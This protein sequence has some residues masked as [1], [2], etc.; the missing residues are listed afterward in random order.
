MSNNNSNV[1][2]RHPKKTLVILFFVFFL[3]LDFGGAAVL[4][5]LGL[6]EPSYTN[7][8]T[9]EAVYRRTDKIFHHTL[10]KN[11]T[12]EKA[13]WGGHH[14]TVHTNSLGFKDKAIREIKLKIDKPR[15]LFIGDSF[16][17]GVGIEYK[18]TF[19]GLVDSILN[20]K[21]INVLN[22]AATSYAPIIYLRKV[23]YLLNEVGLKF[24][25]LVVFVDLSD[26]EDEAMGYIFNDQRSVVSRNTIE[27]VGQTSEE[28]KDKPFSLKEFFT[29]YTIIT[30]R[31]RNLSAYLK[32]QKRSWHD[33]LNRR[34]ARWT[35]D[36][37]IYN[38]YGKTGLALAQQHMT[39]LKQLLDKHQIKMTL[40]VYPWPDQI[41]A[42]NYP[43]KQS[44]TWQAWTQQHNVP[45]V[46]LFPAFMSDDAEQT[47]KTY[48]INGDVH[49]NEKGHALVADQIL[50]ILTP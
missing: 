2:E 40:A 30:G 19:V 15:I 11:V 20:K 34:R 29:E 8:K 9:L 47:I 49:W 24:D 12:Q 10:K 22:A 18:N 38:Q 48:Y 14:Y 36:N 37:K 50:K 33:S 35:L 5:V 44:Q 27:K 28:P 7:S 3:M 31:L 45:F 43:N 1:F 21:N 39:K 17:E 4:K 41:Y 16:T 6:F 26:I 23:D 25:H 46:D 13:E 32:Q 42:R